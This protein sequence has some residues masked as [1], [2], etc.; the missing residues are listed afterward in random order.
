MW[1]RLLRADR[2]G[3]IAVPAWGSPPVTH[4]PDGEDRRLTVFRDI[5]R[6]MRPGRLLD[7][8][9]G[10]GKFAVIAQEL[11]WQ[12]TAVDARTERMPMTPGIEWIRAD[13]R[14]FDVGGY[15]CIALLGLLYHLEFQDV[16]SLLRRCAGTPTILDTHTALRADQVEQGYEG[17]TFQELE[18]ATP[19]R[20]A[21]T[22]TAAWGNPT[23]WWPTR[24]ALV[25]LL[26]NSGFGTILVLD[27]PT[28][29]DRTFY[30]CL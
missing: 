29:A 8:G 23:S 5:L 20:L 12:V 26:R 19:D 16:R 18:D 7:L 30:L 4:S 9:T 13:V 21:A 27:P 2:S 14:A 22:P 1:R 15:D 11:G 6:P 3:G 28:G 25:R 17:R 24:S 10:H